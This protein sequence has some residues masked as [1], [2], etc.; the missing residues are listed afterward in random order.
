MKRRSLIKG[1]AL[2]PLAMSVNFDAFAGEANSVD[3]DDFRSI[4]NTLNS[5]DVFAII[6][7]KECGILRYKTHWDWKESIFVPFATYHNEN[8]PA[9][10]F[11]RGHSI[12]LEYWNNGKMHNSIGPSNIL[13]NNLKDSKYYGKFYCKSFHQEGILH[14][15]NG[16]SIVVRGKEYCATF[17]GTRAW[18][19]F[20]IHGEHYS[21]EEYWKKV[22]EIKGSF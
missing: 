1:M 17:Q 3:D 7:T 19:V 14:N 16:P 18:K 9:A 2:A 20:A 11:N 6:H 5:R 10:I 8:G 12:V 15:L 21:E 13:I 4:C 22:K